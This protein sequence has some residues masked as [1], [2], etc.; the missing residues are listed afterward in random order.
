MCAC[1]IA[2][3]GCVIWPGVLHA[4]LL[5]PLHVADCV[6]ALCADDSNLMARILLP[7]VAVLAVDGT[8]LQD[9][10]LMLCTGLPQ[11]ELC[12]PDSPRVARGDAQLTR[13]RL[14]MCVPAL[15]AG[16]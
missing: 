14:R 9:C 15:G 7:A 13:K 6:C 4:K 16:A 2:C 11:C 5:L 1:V 3:A 10:V 12:D 8:P